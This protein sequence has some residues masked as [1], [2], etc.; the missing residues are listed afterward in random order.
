MTTSTARTTHEPTTSPI[1]IRLPLQLRITV[2]PMVN[3]SVL[4]LR[5]TVLPLV[6]AAVLKLRETVFPV[7][8]DAVLQLRNTVLTLVSVAVLQLRATVL[9]VINDAV[10]PVIH[11]LRLHDKSLNLHTKLLAAQL[12]HHV[13]RRPARRRFHHSLRFHPL[14]T[15]HRRRP[16]L[17]HLLLRAYH[18]LVT[19]GVRLHHHTFIT[20]TL[21]NRINRLKRLHTLLVT[22]VIIMSNLHRGKRL[23]RRRT[24]VGWYGGDIFITETRF[25]FLGGF[26]ESKVYGAD[27]SVKD[28]E[29][30]EK[31]S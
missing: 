27:E 21:L 26:E 4:Q 25:L 19:L 20:A 14:M 12:I 24:D 28:D 5:E 16:R 30:E 11:H 9:P 1:V 13:P 8:R 31:V 7:I 6:N 29:N 17:L 22:R 2:L 10:L 15:L 18:P 23:L 3:A